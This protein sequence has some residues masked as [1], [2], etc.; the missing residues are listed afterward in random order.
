MRATITISLELDSYH[1]SS[2]PDEA[3]AD[4]ESS[5]RSFAVEYGDVKTLLVTVQG[6]RRKRLLAPDWD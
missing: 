5:F 4:L 3:K 6:M 2:D 1:V